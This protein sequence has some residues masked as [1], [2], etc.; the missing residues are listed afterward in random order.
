VIAE[1][2]NRSSA[3][4]LSEGL[5]P[6]RGDPLKA[7]ELKALERIGIGPLG[8]YLGGEEIKPVR[9]KPSGFFFPGEGRH[10]Q[11]AAEFFCTALECTRTFWIAGGTRTELFRGHL[12][13]L[14]TWGFSGGVFVEENAGAELLGTYLE[15]LR[16]ECPKA[17]IL[18]LMP[19]DFFETSL[20][21]FLRTAKPF[22]DPGNGEIPLNT[23]AGGEP[24]LGLALEGLAL[25][26]Y[27]AIP[28]NLRALKP[29]CDILILISAAGTDPPPETSFIGARLKLTVFLGDN[30]E[31]KTGK[32]GPGEKNP[33]VHSYLFRNLVPPKAGEPPPVLG[34]P[35]AG[36]GRRSSHKNPP[37]AQAPVSFRQ[38]GGAPV[39]FMPRP[40]PRPFSGG[41]EEA[42]ALGLY[43]QWEAGRVEAAAGGLF[44]VDAKFSGIRGMDFQE[45][46]ALFYTPGDHTKPPRV[47]PPVRPGSD[48]LELSPEQRNFFFFWRNECRRGRFF[49]EGVE[50]ADPY[51]RIYARELA[52]SMGQEGPWHHFLVLR[53]LFH[54]CR[55]P[56][57][58]TGALLCRWLLDFAVIYGLCAEALPLL[59]DELWN[60]GPVDEG[61]IQGL[62]GAFP[63]VLDLSIH[64]FFIE[65][66]CIGKTQTEGGLFSD[67]PAPHKDASFPPGDMAVQDPSRPRTPPHRALGEVPFAANQGPW[68]CVGS[69]IPRNIL[70]QR[71]P[72]ADGEIRRVLSGIDR[73]LREDWN[74]GIFQ[75]FYPPQPVKESCKAFEDP[76]R[77][78]GSPLGESSYR[79]YRGAFSSHKPLVD[80][81]SAVFLDPLSNPLP[82]ARSPRQPLTLEGELLEKLRRESNEVRELLKTQEGPEDRKPFN[83]DNRR[84]LPNRYRAPGKTAMGEFI[85]SLSRPDYHTLEALIQGETI[86]DMEADTINRAFNDL[87][88]DLLIVYQGD[89]PSISGEY[90]SI[91]KESW[92]SPEG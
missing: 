23:T 80:F 91:L 11:T 69:L 33:P 81:L 6:P 70:R 30:K 67:D 86:G 77:I 18:V 61:L 89:V 32:S 27:E 73:R 9:L 31:H 42:A 10:R 35:G 2:K 1:G 62:H 85:A 49:P 92:R 36:G 19:R 58:E 3:L 83:E 60:G 38:T 74:R 57:P 53:D 66:N 16:R 29:R 79:V 22:G 76:R 87:F 24:V 13:F 34:F 43:T 65:K 46:Q 64:Y 20:K 51:I 88:G 71:D 28:P 44:A 17:K 25:G 8:R 12:E 72:K 37:A 15:F 90:L 45:E 59:M 75:F 40:G 84:L 56:F 50:W 4:G 7:E 54:H 82:G 21:R 52:L 47:P 68:G 63:L 41:G 55:E 14:R 39:F 5:S 78:H 26:W 48:F